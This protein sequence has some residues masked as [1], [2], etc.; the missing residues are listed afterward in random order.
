TRG[1]LLVWVLTDHPEQVF[2]PGRRLLLGDDS[3][4]PG[5]VPQRVEVESSWLYRKGWLVKL[6]DVADRT[7]AE[8]LTGRYLLVPAG[9]REELAEGEYYYHQ[10]LGLRVET[11][12]GEVVGRVREVYETEP[13]HMLEVRG[14]RVHLIPFRRGLVRRV[15]LD[16]RRL[17]IDPPEGLLEL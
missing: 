11:T 6:V 13:H 5:P 8:T 9:E 17:E 10:L 12:A 2:E 7:Q 16:A 15:D 4:G 1:E 3:G 14:E